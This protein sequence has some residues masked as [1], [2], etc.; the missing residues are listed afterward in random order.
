M[1][2]F[3][4][5]GAFGAALA[6]A[7]LSFSSNHYATAQQ[8]TEGAENVF[9][10]KAVIITPTVGVAGAPKENVRVE[11]LADRKYIVYQVTDDDNRT[12]DYWMAVDQVSRIK[13]FPNME[14]ATAFYD[15]RH[16]KGVSQ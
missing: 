13:V 3:W 5:C 7:A 1:K 11:V 10:G 2:Q 9:P 14:E 4:I 12:Y 16:G 15:S 6:L 8:G